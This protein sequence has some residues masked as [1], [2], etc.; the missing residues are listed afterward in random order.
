M[1]GARKFIPVLVICAGLYAYH[2]SFYGPFIFDDLRSIPGNP[3]IRR[4]WPLWRVMWPPPQ[5]TVSARPIV[6]LS[7]ALNYAFG[8]LNVRGYHTF[9]LAIHILAALVLYGI[10]RRTL[11]RPGLREPYGAAA[12]W[13]ALAVALIW[14]VHPVQTESVTYIVQRTELLMGLFFLLTLYC[15]IRGAESPRAVAWYAAAVV[16]SMLGM[17]SKEVMAVAPVVVLA[18]DRLFLSTSFRETCRRR[19]GLYA[20]LA[21]SWLIF[22]ALP[23]QMRIGLDIP[24]LSSS[25]V[26][27]W[28]YAKTQTGV[29]VHY[30]RLAFWPDPLVADYD[31]WPL[32]RSV[33]TILA[34]AAVVLTL[35]GATLWAFHRRLQ[36]AFLGVWFFVILAPSSSF[37]PLLT[38]FAAERRLYLP[39]AA[40]IVLVV[41]GG[42]VALGDVCRRL[43]WQPGRRRLLEVG[44][45]VVMVATLAHL[46]VRRN[47]DY[48]STASFWGDVVAKRPN[49]GRGHNYLGAYLLGQ[50]RSDEAARHLSEAVR[51]APNRPEPH[52]N[53]GLALAGQGKLQE[54]I[55]QYSRAL[56]IKPDDADAHYYL[57]IALAGLGKLDDANA[58]YS[59]VIRLNPNDAR[60]YKNL[61][62]TLANQG[63]LEEAIAQYSKALRISPNYAEVHNNLGNALVAERK[64][65]EAIAHYA[66]AIRIRPNY[67]EAHYNLGIA[68]AGQGKVEGAIGHYAEAIRINPNYAQAHNNLATAL[69]NQEKW[70]E[71]IAHYSEALRIAPSPALHYNLATALAR[72]GKTQEAIRH[73]EAALKLNPGFQPARR[74]LQNLTSSGAK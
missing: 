22:A 16:S 23:L 9:N 38:E 44:V 59:E 2:N 3:T 24:R 28:N 74:A 50:G 68:L 5:T 69:A 20:G 72:D 36:L 43:G 49:N 4:L 42:H 54:A 13:L 55:A 62:T 34:P 66:E 39:L 11:L 65:Q 26:T 1:A 71:A 64:P 56:R 7:F 35:L 32:A 52:Y 33:A 45:L 29:I 61:G 19:W 70:K 57:G 53:L 40:V 12:P 47:E 10:V 60:G 67:A 8:G 30:L 48:R 46:A 63:R 14:V 41:I 21:A 18:Y 6:N 31:D 17:G 15:V 37:W 73:L 25:G 58:Q 51:L 27:R